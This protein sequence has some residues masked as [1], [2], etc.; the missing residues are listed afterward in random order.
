MGLNFAIDALYATGW[1]PLDPARCKRGHDSRSYPD[2]QGIRDIFAEH[3]CTLTLRHV[4]LFDC[5][6]AEWREHN[7]ST[8]A[9]AVVG[10]TAE[11]AAVYALSQLRR[12]VL[13]TDA[14]KA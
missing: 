6:R 11:E 14:A 13:T 1:T 2:E 5:Y 12:Q 4:Q 3:G 9:G 7:G 10:Q 8:I